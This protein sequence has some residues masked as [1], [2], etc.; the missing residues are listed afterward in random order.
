MEGT[1]T[2]PHGECCHEGP[3]RFSRVLHAEV[4]LGIRPDAAKSRPALFWTAPDRFTVSVTP[5]DS[6]GNVIAPSRAPA[7]EVSI[8]GKPAPGTFENPHT[9]ELRVAFQ[10]QGENA[11]PNKD[12]QSLAAK[13][14]IV[15][16]K[17][18]RQIEIAPN[19]KLKISLVAGAVS[20]AVELP[21]FIGDRESRRAYP[22]GSPEA[23][24]IA[25]ENRE[26]FRNKKE[27]EAAGYKI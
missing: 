12:G 13:A 10:L 16:D 5:T 26:P 11:Q 9:G 3:Q 7:P 15:D 17:G 6:L 18:N 27:A 24:R 14:W 19:K 8:N 22:A 23:M 1:V 4:A 2:L 21:A 25:L 20:M